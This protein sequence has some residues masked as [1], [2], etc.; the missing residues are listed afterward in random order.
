MSVMGFA[1]AL[2]REAGAAVSPERVIDRC[3]NCGSRFDRRLNR[4]RHYGSREHAARPGSA[5]PCGCDLGADYVC[6]WHS[7]V[8]VPDRKTRSIDVDVIS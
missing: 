5:Q 3:M 6:E 2:A 8:G 7:V 4:R 1:Q